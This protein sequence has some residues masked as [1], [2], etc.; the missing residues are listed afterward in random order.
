M[1]PVD[2]NRVKELFDA[3][4]EVE[5]SQR[6]GFLAEHAQD[7]E[8]REQVERLLRNYQPADSF[9]DNPVL[10]RLWGVRDDE[11]SPGADAATSVFT[12]TTKAQPE[13]PMAG[14]RL[15]AYKVM[16]RI[17]RGGMASVFLATRADDEYHKEV[18]IKVVPPELDSGELFSRLRNE[19]Q[20]LAD[21]DHPNI[22]KL[23]D[24]GST[25]EGLPFLVMDY[26]QGSPIDDY[27]DQHKLSI[28]ERLRL[29][30][31]VCEA[32]QYA[33]EKSIVHRDLKPTNILVTDE[34][35]P[36]VLDFGIS[37]VLAPHPFGQSPITKT[38][39]RCMTPAYA[40]PEQMRGKL[41]TTATDI[42]SLGVVLYELL[43]GHRPY[44]LK[45][46]TPVEMERA[47]CGQ[48]PE[49][50]STAV[51][52]VETEI[53]SD[54]IP[55]TTTPELVS[56]A[57]EEDPEKLRRHLRGDLDNIVLKALQKEPARRYASV[58]E[59][60]QDLVRHLQHLPVEARRPTLIYR[61]SRFVRRHTTEIGAALLVAL[62]F[63]TTA[64]FAF[65]PF[66]LRDRV[67]VKSTVKAGLVRT[68]GWVF[69]TKSP[70]R[71]I[72]PSVSC[73]TLM[74][75]GLPNTTI[76][77]TQS[78]ITGSFAPPGTDV[79]HDLPAF[80]RVQGAIRPA[81]DSDIRFEVWMPSS[82]WNG[83]FRGVGNGGFG[84]SINFEDMAPAIRRG[85]AS[86]STD[87]GHRGDDTD[88]GWALRHPEKII[89]FGYRAIHEMTEKSKQ[90]I[91]VF[92]GQRPSWSYFEGCSNGGREGLIEAQR[93]PEDYQGILAGAS[94][95]SMHLLAA[96][97]FNNGI[98]SES[99][100]PPN[101]L[102]TIGAAVL[103]A[104]DALDGITDGIL[105][106][107]RQCHFDPSI[108][109]CRG[110]DSPSCLTAPQVAQLHKIYQG[111]QTSS[112]EE[113]FP[114]YLPGGEEGDEGWKAWITGPKPEHGWNF[115]LGRGVFRDM[116]FSDPTWDHRTIKAE[117][118]D[119]IANDRMG[120][121][122][123]STDPD[124]R[125]FQARGGKLILY[126]GWSDPESPGLVSVDYYDA[127]LATM[128]RPE[129]DQFA[130]LYM[131]PGMQH[132]YAGPGPNFFGQFDPSA[133][134]ANADQLSIPM[135][136]EHN[137]S[138]ALQRW[139]EQ[140]IAP[141]TLIATKY[142]NDSDPG[143]GVKMTRPL[144]PYPK[145]AVYMGSGDTNEASNFVCIQANSQHRRT[146]AP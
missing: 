79:I 84:G 141:D 40:S 111:L 86:A 140:G 75:L 137:I 133:L 56:A 92:Y 129:V 61:A 77:A 29:F 27:C 32:V 48:D 8:T 139:V 42:Y 25:P 31:K 126:H 105:N 67:G 14:R 117:Q 35:T 145:V 83:K 19:R 114:G 65:N 45:E 9:L 44:R 132:C 20:T 3:V 66:G 101:K 18:A 72:A 108:L 118:A 125:R 21:L 59:F 78:V 91:Q 26:V 41:V 109:L 124:L 76:I 87:T 10:D 123:S 131:A 104:C 100:I 99:Y 57:R 13:E 134:S 130:R 85:Y 88:S 89:D 121:I 135:D 46:N 71:S 136:P 49:P 15:G 52:R 7:D 22:V 28:D 80:C 127:L 110:A 142:V 37:K 73:D 58:G 69:G 70:A 34:G 63:A 11:E 43:S 128:G 93:F 53:T 33:H 112:G 38:G 47:I 1:T 143:A 106:D 82:G 51:T 98:D 138:L 50:P 30:S 17:G 5:P 94:P 60:S 95:M 54:G 64:V 36:K 113:L 16:K 120:P 97:L 122:L 55:I 144:C 39:A 116:V 23:L 74:R 62:A 6:A 102:H 12:L 103:A 90:I 81:A 68:K 4:L 119:Q 96:G 146:L 115:I 2:W 24:G 107:P